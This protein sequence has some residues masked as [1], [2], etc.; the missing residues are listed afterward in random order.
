MAENLYMYFLIALVPMIV[1][2]IY[3][4]PKLVGSAWMK[5]NGFS[6][7]DLEGG[8]M[9]LILGL[10]Y[11]LSLFFTIG[12]QTVTIHQMGAVQLLMPEAL[13]HGSK[14]HSD[15][16]ALLSEYAGNHRSFGHGALHGIMT[17]MTF[18]LPVLGIVAL[19]ERRGFKYVLIH[20]IYWMITI[21]I[22]SGLV[23][24]TLVFGA[25]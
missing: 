22:M 16:T 15:L 23:A 21:V 3:Y 24:S 25:I 18:A 4:H 7:Q 2:S 11:L 6:M 20:L 9:A 1:G 13:E 8:N 12:L 10:A 19:F 17:T 5:A 14:A